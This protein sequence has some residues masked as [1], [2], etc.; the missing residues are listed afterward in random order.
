VLSR[1]YL[2]RPAKFDNFRDEKNSYHKNV[3]VAQKLA[4]QKTVGLLE[5]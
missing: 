3:S 5:L 2:F 4:G 1:G